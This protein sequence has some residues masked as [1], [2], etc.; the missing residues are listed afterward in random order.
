MPAQLKTPPKLNMTWV[1]CV[2]GRVR[3]GECGDGEEEVIVAGGECVC[4]WRE[5]GERGLDVDIDSEISASRLIIKVH[6][7]FT[8]EETS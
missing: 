7:I 3:V 2:C 4:G 6:F 1:H 8:L 5:G